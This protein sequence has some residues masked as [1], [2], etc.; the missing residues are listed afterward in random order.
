MRRMPAPRPMNRPEETLNVE[1]WKLNVERFFPK[2]LLLAIGLIWSFVPLW[3]ADTVYQV[4]VA[5]VDVTPEYPIRLNGF[6]FRRTE[7]EGVTQRIWA[8]ALAIGDPD[9]AVGPVVLVTV[10][11]LAIP[12][13]LTQDVA[14]RLSKRVKLVSTR[15]TITCTHTHTAPMLRDVCPT[16]F[17][18]PIPA[19]HLAHID[20]YTREL[21]DQIEQ[22]AL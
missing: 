19:E 15:F 5:Q 7:S 13:Y 20:R 1:G 17:G 4:G 18:V 12:D 14:G 22:V 16:I 10:D 6:G 2:H 8:K 3:A 9:P 11:N 21:T